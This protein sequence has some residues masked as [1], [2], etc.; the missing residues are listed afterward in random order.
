MPGRRQR[1]GGE[2]GEPC[3]RAVPGQ[4]FEPKGVA[5]L[6]RAL[7]RPGFDGRPAG[8]HLAGG[9]DA[10]A[11]AQG[12]EL[13]C[14]RVCALHRLVRPAAGRATARAPATLLVL[15]SY[16]E[17][18][19]LVILEALANSV[20]V[21]CTPVGEIHPFLPTRDRAFVTPGDAQ[22][23][24]ARSPAAAA[25]LAGAPGRNGRALYEQQFSLAAFSKGA[26][27]IHQRPFRRAAR[28]AGDH[29]G[30]GT[31]S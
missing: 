3:S 19:P 27:R 7:A 9:G 1:G 11:Q 8:G 12:G 20:A 2:P 31:S 30:R 17:G 14:R 16:D 21:V 25:A 26:A 18:L 6:L 24:P 10:R 29:R 22:G 28:G 23:S 13:G 15:P 5:D 4:S